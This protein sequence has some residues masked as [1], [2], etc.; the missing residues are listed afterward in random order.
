MSKAVKRRRQGR[1][2]QPLSPLTQLVLTALEQ[3]ELSGVTSLLGAVAKVLGADACI[4]WQMAPDMGSI[5]TRDYLFVLAQWVGLG[6]QKCKARY[7]PIH[8]SVTG[9]AVL[10]EQAINV[11]DIKLDK[12]VYSG[13]KFL[14]EARIV[15]MISAPVELRP[16]IKAALNLY[17]K[18]KKTFGEGEHRRI[19]ELVQLLPSLYQ[20][21]S[22]RVGLKMIGTVNDIL[23]QAELRAPDRPLPKS[24][25]KKVIQSICDF[26]KESFDCIETSVFLEDRLARPAEF[27]MMATTWPERFQKPVY[28]R[29]EGLTGWVLEN[30]APVNIFDLLKFNDEVKFY[31][32]RYHDIT[33]SDPLDIETAVRKH[34]SPEFDDDDLPPLS[35][36]AAPILKGTSVRGAVRCCVTWKAPYYFSD[37]ELK[38]LVLIASQISRYWSN[39]MARQEI[40]EENKSWKELVNGILDLNSFVH[41]ELAKSTP[42]RGLI[43]ERALEQ[44]PSVIT[45]AD[46]MDVRLYDPDTEQLYFASTFGLAWEEGDQQAIE[47]RRKRRFPVGELEDE[48]AGARVFRTGKPAHIKDVTDDPNYSVTF[49]ETTHMLI[50]PISVGED[51]YGVLDI[52]STHERDFPSYAEDM[53]LLLAKQLGLYCYLAEHVGQLH[54][55]QK[56]KLQTYEDLEHQLLN[57]VFLAHA[58]IQQ[59]LKTQ[60][61][62]KQLDEDEPL[63]TELQRVRGICGK[64][65]RV[66]LSTW[67]FVN[68]SQGKPVD[69]KLERLK[70]EDLIMRLIEAAM[71]NELTIDP[72]RHIRFEVRRESFEIVKTIDVRVDHSFLEQAIGNIMDNASKYSSPNSTVRIYGGLTATR[73]FHIS[74]AN[75]GIRIR[76]ED[77][78]HCVERE[79]RSD[80][81]RLVTSEG[82]GIG[83]YIV[84]NL[85]RAQGGEL[86]ITPTVE[87]IT[88]IKLVFPQ[89]KHTTETA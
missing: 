80:Y 75:K 26:I 23:H 35:F 7:L 78:K 1:G 3:H 77:V 29:K 87:K 57:P 69:P 60:R 12:R 72:E 38:L 86:I 54:R 76:P 85:Q 36:I 37:V 32:S 4:L 16:G 5:P 83:L 56:E 34:L 65:V 59:L 11:P 19:K 79:W 18:S 2:G 31:R 27:E 53:A 33:W 17:W 9:A 50:C 58:R 67:M 22:D 63:K 82:S 89:F 55:V 84:D 61:F 25:V 88:D 10:G 15:S 71:D 21:L 39:W 52:R 13:D 28:R 14:A 6:E 8:G 43:F 24:E 41:G 20:T 47:R 74:V 30:A 66:T 46:I 40:Q 73:R 68:L 70:H 42:D 64:A 62:T 49:P 44:A 81:A 45:G 51:K 48:S